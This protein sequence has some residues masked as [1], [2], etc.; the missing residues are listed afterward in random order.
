MR[1]GG[2]NRW[3]CVCVCVCVCVYVISQRGKTTPA[4]KVETMAGS[5]F[6]MITF[7]TVL[8]LY[9]NCNISWLA[10]SL[11]GVSMACDSGLNHF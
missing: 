7:V 2:V 11:T 3:V 4:Q 8:S 1:E 9:T 5:V 6:Y 10:F